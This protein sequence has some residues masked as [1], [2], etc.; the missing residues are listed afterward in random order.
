M[1]PEDVLTVIAG[2]I[3]FRSRLRSREEE[4]R[5]STAEQVTMIERHS[6]ATQRNKD[7]SSSVCDCYGA[8]FC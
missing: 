5:V 3:S 2:A 8:L 4:R 6:D 7:G 1:L